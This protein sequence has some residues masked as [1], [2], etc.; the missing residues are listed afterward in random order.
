MMRAGKRDR[1]LTLLRLTQTR[2]DYGGVTDDFAAVAT[3]WA[4]YEPLSDA[5]QRR[6]AEVGATQTARFRVLLSSLTA[7]CDPTWRVVLHGR[8]GA[9]D[10]EF[11]IIG[12]KDVVDKGEEWRPGTPV[13]LEISA[14][15]RA[16][17]GA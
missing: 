10:V 1:R 6:A 12:V 13:G 7:L 8:R 9:P 16:E 11:D 14:V 17:K 15:A 3:V 2:D 5:E 4:E